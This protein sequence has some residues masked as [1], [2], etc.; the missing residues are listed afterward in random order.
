MWV[1]ANVTHVLRHLGRFSTDPGRASQTSAS[2][3]RCNGHREDAMV[4]MHRPG[5]DPASIQLGQCRDAAGLGE[6]EA[7]A[8]T[9][10]ANT[11]TVTGTTAD[12]IGS[13]RRPKSV[14]SR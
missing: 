13:L 9:T 11:I 2:H 12:Q 6:G 4:E 1:H 7:D 5:D 14:P 8:R 3:P 10:N